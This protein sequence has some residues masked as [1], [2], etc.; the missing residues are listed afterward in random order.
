MISSNIPVYL[1]YSVRK[2]QRTNK[3]KEFG[4][5]LLCGVL[6][7]YRLPINQIES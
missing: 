1:E 3:Q 2:I 4:L 5:F 7:S 6:S